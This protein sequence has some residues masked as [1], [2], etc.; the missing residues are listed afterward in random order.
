MK[1]L[2]RGLNSLFGNFND[3]LD[4]VNE[5]PVKETRLSNEKT[6]KVSGV[7]EIEVGLIDRNINQP[8]KHFDEKALNELAQSIKQHGIIQP[9]ILQ[10]IG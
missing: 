9:L 5:K 1:G 8:R 6:E 2:G 10:K 4:D 7:T 3:D